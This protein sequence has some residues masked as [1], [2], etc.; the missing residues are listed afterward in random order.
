MLGDLDTEDQEALL[1]DQD[2]MQRTEFAIKDNFEQS[3]HQGSVS[4]LRIAASHLFTL[5]SLFY[6]LTLV[7]W[8][9]PNGEYPYSMLFMI[10]L[11]LF[12]RVSFIVCL[13]SLIFTV[14]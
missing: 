3:K 1:P 13:T 7:F 6:F 8:K 4:V 10:I 5:K 9:H 11:L 12:L 2:N 14:P